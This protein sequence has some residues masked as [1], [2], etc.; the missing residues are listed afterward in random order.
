MGI[1]ERLTATAQPFLEPGDV[2]LQ[3]FRAGPRMASGRKSPV[4]HIV[5]GTQDAIVILSTSMWSTRRAKSL[6]VRLPR[7]TT[8]I[9]LH[10]GELRIG[11]MR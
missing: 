4:V 7:S 10:L 9:S 6:L 2:V 5:V 1:R 11:G 8:P 3:A